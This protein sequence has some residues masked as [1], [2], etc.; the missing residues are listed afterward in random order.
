MDKGYGHITVIQVRPPS[1][2]YYKYLTV[3]A[4]ILDKMFKT[5]IYNLST[6]IQCH[7]VALVGKAMEI[8]IIL[9]ISSL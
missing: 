9:F 4:L 5:N 3:S 2:K 8:C 7:L 6:C 1:V